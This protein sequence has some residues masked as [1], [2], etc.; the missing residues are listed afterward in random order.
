M[1]APIVHSEADQL[2]RLGQHLIVAEANRLTRVDDPDRHVSAA[3]GNLA[4][5]FTESIKPRAASTHGF[6]DQDSDR[7][8]TRRIF[9]ELSIGDL[10]SERDHFFSVG[11]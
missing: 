6:V 9:L 7:N 10:R 2:R 5:L 3:R 1:I 11:N 8:A 4:H